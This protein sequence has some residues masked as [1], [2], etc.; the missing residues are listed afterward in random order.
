MHAAGCC[1]SLEKFPLPVFSP[2]SSDAR[3]GNK[4]TTSP[5]RSPDAKVEALS[6]AVSN[7]SVGYSGVSLKNQ[8]CI[9]KQLVFLANESQVLPDQYNPE[10]SQDQAMNC[11][12]S[13]PQPALEIVASDL[14]RQHSTVEY[15]AGMVHSDNPLGLL[16][17][18][19]S[20]SIV[21]VA[22]SYNPSAGE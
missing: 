3:A 19:S 18:F 12:A 1:H 2:T 21:M 22:K 9:L 6:T 15:L 11:S 14:C 7:L 13:S 20:W 16:P 4:I 8:T 17:K 10:A 5:L